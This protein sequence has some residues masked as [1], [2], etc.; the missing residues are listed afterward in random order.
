MQK[1]NIHYWLALKLVPRLA[2]HKKLALV[3][4]YGLTALFSLS[5]LTS[6]HQLSP[7]Q[8]AA[9]HQPDWQTI[10]EIISDSKRCH[11][12][13]LVFDDPTY[14]ELLKQIYD[15]PLVLFIQGNKQLLN[16]HQL[17]IVGSRSASI[18]GR[19]TAFEIAQQLSGIGLIITSG[20]ALG[21]DASAH[22]GALTS[23][24]STIAVVATG[25]DIVYP[26]RHRGLAS[27]IIENEGAII[28]EF[29][30]GTSPKP[31]HFPKRNRIIS[32]LSEGV[33]VVEAAL[34]SGSLIT[35]RCALEQ[36]RDVFSIPSGIGNPQ[37]KGCHWLIKQGAKLVEE[38]AD[39]IEE[40]AFID[41]AS[42][43]LKQQDKLQSIVNQEVD[44]K[45]LNKDLCVDEL[46]ASVGFEI[47]PIDKVVS[48]S[49]LPV[50]EVLTRLTMLELSGL[51]A[52]V[53]G[54]YL[55]LQ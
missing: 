49:N 13:I 53:P 40:L 46:L 9:F 37:A 1:S 2:I 7:K 47:T 26:A 39:I 23:K 15:P 3:D 21:I 30:P 10:D 44:E 8:L 55:R 19:E 20:L 41:K 16:K 36:N 4:T 29:L 17:A 28:S 43:H 6:S 50:E 51:V 42:L 35:A 45:K 18:N 34:Q 12:E 38:T 52:A 33:L 48:R 27:Q 54:G 5:K 31:G 25:L 11:S 14:P 22:K 24:A 32:G